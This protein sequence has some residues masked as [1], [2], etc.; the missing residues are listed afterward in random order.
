MKAFAIAIAA[1]LLGTAGAAVPLEGAQATPSR[2]RG[3][4]APVTQAD[5]QRLQDAVYDASSDM[6][7]L[8]DRDARLAESLQRDLDDLRDEVIYL[9]VKLRKE[10]SVSRTEF[11]DLRDRI[12][13]LRSQA[14]GEPAAGR[15]TS[16][17]EP[18]SPPPM[19]AMSVYLMGIPA[20]KHLFCA[21]KGK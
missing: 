18:A 2:G 21:E 10:Q 4:Q 15:S 5:I 19:I 17:V 16:A 9:K 13:Q 6:S 8:R 20:W 7:R 12:E 11:T 1:L 3:A 14:R